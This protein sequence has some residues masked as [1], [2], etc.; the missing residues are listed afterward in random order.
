MKLRKRIL[1]PTVALAVIAA[2][3]PTPPAVA[4]EKKHDHDVELVKLG[5]YASGS[6]TVAGRRSAPSTRSRSGSSS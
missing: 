2:A 4:K 6:S 3:R 5:T 1:L